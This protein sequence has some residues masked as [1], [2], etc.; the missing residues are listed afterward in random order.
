MMNILKALEMRSVIA[1]V[2]VVGA[3][4]LAVVEPEYG[5]A[6]ISILSTAV[7]GYFGQLVGHDKDKP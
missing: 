5:T 1:L 3:I 6:S 7:G 4:G 2:S